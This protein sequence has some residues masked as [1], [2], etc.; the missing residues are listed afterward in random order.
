MRS[1]FIFFS[2]LFLT[3]TCGPADARSGKARD[4][5]HNVSVSHQ[6][7]FPRV[8]SALRGSSASKFTRTGSSLFR[9]RVAKQIS[10][11]RRFQSRA[12]GKVHA[13]R[14]GQAKSSGTPRRQ[15]Q[16]FG[17]ETPTGVKAELPPAQ[18]IE[19]GFDCAAVVE[20][21]PNKDNPGCYPVSPAMRRHLEQRD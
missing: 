9:I 19:A 10:A 11:T 21:S 3:W 20:L 17:V 7:P 15:A 6:K 18:R 13:F 8:G 16:V 1:A 2:A 12:I 4:T 5:G 14:W